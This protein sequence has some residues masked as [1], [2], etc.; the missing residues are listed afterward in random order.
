MSG[1]HLPYDGRDGHPYLRFAEACGYELSLYEVARHL[2]LPV[3]D[4]QI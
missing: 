4:E 2:T 1:S 3:P